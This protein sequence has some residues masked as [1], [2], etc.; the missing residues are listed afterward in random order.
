[1]HAKMWKTIASFYHCELELISPLW[2]H[3]RPSRYSKNK[4]FLIVIFCS[5]SEFMA[6]PRFPIYL[7]RC[8][9]RQCLERNTLSLTNGR[10][11]KENEPPR[12]STLVHNTF[13]LILVQQPQ[14][15]V[16]TKSSIEQGFWTIYRPRVIILWRSLM[17]T[18]HQTFCV[19]VFPLRFKQNIKLFF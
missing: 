14:T 9:A 4:S 17:I 10:S 8:R 3:F 12:L 11:F 16:L 6:R 19:F 15:L 2:T 13:E 1:M 18:S 5:V 7:L